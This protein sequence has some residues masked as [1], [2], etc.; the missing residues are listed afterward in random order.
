[1]LLHHVNF[2]LTSCDARKLA[3]CAS[4][5]LFSGVCFLVSLQFLCIYCFIFTLIAGEWFFLG[6]PLD[7]PFEVG[8]PVTRKVA[9]CALVRLLLGVNEE[10]IFQITILTK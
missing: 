7:M 9:L 2:Q 3:G 1:M 4:L 5:W 10:V 8:S 6:V